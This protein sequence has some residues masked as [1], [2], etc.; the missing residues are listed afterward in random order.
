MNGDVDAGFETAERSKAAVITVLEFVAD[1]AV[2]RVALYKGWM[3]QQRRW[4]PWKKCA[5]RVH[6]IRRCGGSPRV[7]A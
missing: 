4:T 2:I 3:R 6:S 7:D 5:S 1:I